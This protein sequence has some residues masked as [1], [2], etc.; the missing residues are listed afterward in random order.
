[1]NPYKPSPPDGGGYELSLLWKV[2]AFIVMWTVLIGMFCVL[3]SIAD[4]IDYGDP[5]FSFG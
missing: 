2:A 3:I 4:W 1:M 5:F